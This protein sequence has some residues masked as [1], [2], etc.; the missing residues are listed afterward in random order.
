LRAH[1]AEG[2]WPFSVFG[3]VLQV[4]HLVA[5]E[6]VRYMQSFCR[7]CEVQLLC[8]AHFVGASVADSR[9]LYT[10]CLLINQAHVLDVFAC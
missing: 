2:C 5:Q 10:S 6:R 7:S 1:R 9:S 3:L 4:P 8:H